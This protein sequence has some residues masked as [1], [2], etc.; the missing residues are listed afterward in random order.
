MVDTLLRVRS[1]MVKNLGRFFVV[2]VYAFLYMPIIILIIFSFNK[3]P[4]PSR[5]TGFTWQWYH[6]LAR[7]T[8]LW[9]AVMNSMFIAVC[10]TV[11]S[12]IFSVFFIFFLA[13]SRRFERVATF[14]YV[15]TVVPEIVFAVGLLGLFSFLGVPLGRVTLVVAHTILGM[16]YAIPNLFARLSELD[17]RLTEASYDLGASAI[18]TFR[19]VTFPLLRSSVIATGL[20]VFMIS[21]DDF[22]LA[23]F[24]SGSTTQTLPLYLLSL[25]RAEVSPT[26]NALSA[27]LLMFSGSL[28]M[29]FYS[30]NSRAKLF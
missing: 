6:E 11:L 19:F 14:F 13:Q 4:F 9:E 20:F 8:H 26:V 10:A 28:V 27:V 24:C 15:N 22:V 18:E 16:G 21:F 25:M 1:H 3:A 30:Y 17:N 2:G 29:V 7:T 5:W 23:Y 12:L